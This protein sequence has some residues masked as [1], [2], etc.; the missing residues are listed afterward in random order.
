MD[1]SDA[2]PSKDVDWDSP[3]ELTRRLAERSSEQTSASPGLLPG[4]GQLPASVP[5]VTNLLWL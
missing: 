4:P 2:D 5:Q 3:L 1:N